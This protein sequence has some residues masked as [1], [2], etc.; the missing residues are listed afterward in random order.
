MTRKTIAQIDAERAAFIQSGK[1]ILPT[2]R[3]L[4]CDFPV[5][6]KVLYCDAACAREFASEKEAH[7]ARKE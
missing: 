4:Y 2:G 7:A 6:P 5:A 1:P 3:C